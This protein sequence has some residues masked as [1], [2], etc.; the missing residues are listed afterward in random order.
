MR[1]SPLRHAGA[2]L[3]KRRPL[4]LTF[5]VT[6]RCDARCGFCFSRG[7]A[8]GRPARTLDGR[9]RAAGAVGRAA[10]LA[11]LLRRRADAAR[12]PPGD[13]RASSPGTAGRSSSCSPPTG[14]TR[15]APRPRPRTAR[16]RTPEHGRRQALAGRAAGASRP[17]ARRPRGARA[18]AGEP[19]AAAASWRRASRASRSAINTVLCAANQGAAD[20]VFADVARLD[21][22]RHPHAEPRA[23]RDPRPRARRGRPGALPRRRRG[24]RPRAARAAPSRATAS[25]ARGSRRRRTSSSGASSPRRCGGR[26]A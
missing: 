11:L 1:H 3:W 7:R 8:G 10:A 22:R 18:R 13:H 4:H 9:D 15:G 12:G 25:A 5:F 6:R 14:S 17:P 16:R 23:R 21:G 2:L 26:G 20:E 24:A 19:R